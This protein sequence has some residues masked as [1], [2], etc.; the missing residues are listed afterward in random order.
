ML[1]ITE[2]EPEPTALAFVEEQQASALHTLYEHVVPYTLCFML[3]TPR[4]PLWRSS[5][6]APYKVDDTTCK[7]RVEE[8][9]V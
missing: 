5:R 8:Y 9:K 4:W 6:P 1:P 3:Y 7:T 2:F